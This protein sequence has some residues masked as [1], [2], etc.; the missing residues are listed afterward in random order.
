M[1]RLFR[2]LKPYTS[3]LLAVAFFLSAQAVFELYLP[4]LMSNVVNNGMMKG[5][6]P[7]IWKYGGWMLVVAMII[8]ICSISSSFL[9]ALIGVGFGR[10]VRNLL[11][12]R[13][14][15][16]S[17]YEFDKIG[18]ASL[19][20]RTTNDVTQVQTLIIMGLRFIIFTPIMCLGG[21]IMAYLK[22]ARLTLILAAVL[23]LMALFIIGTARLVV[24]LFKA[25][26]I[27]LDKVNLVLRENLTGIRVIR[28]F[29]RIGSETRR[30]ETANRD[31]ADNAIRVNKIMALMPLSVNMKI[32]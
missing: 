11:F 17:L 31:L 24:P 7:Y 29:N 20:T 13:I 16:Y 30:F 12:S 19:I 26:Q 5:D 23:P 6:I 21:I 10:D 4:T 28:A 9:S 15:N 3:L 22:D 27:K 1:L 2:Y 8:S 18:T 25:M 32:W 14:Q